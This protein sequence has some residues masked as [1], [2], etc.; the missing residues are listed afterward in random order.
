MSDEGQREAGAG[1][2]EERAGEGA[3]MS[4]LASAKEQLATLQE[5]LQEVTSELTSPEYL[6]FLTKRSEGASGEEKGTEES[7]EPDFDM[8]SQAELAR[9]LVK[10]QKQTDEELKRLIGEQAARV[11][12]ELTCLR[13]PKLRESLNDEKY[14]SQFRQ[15]ALDNPT[16]NAEKVYK[17]VE[18]ERRIAAEE[19]ARMAKEREEREFKARSEKA[20]APL[21]AVEGKLLSDEEA[22]E[23]AYRKVFGT[24]KDEE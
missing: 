6:E 22:E 18:I 14:V 4:E 21:S 17:Q 8:M 5:R 19:A 9:H 11:D 23:I 15:T 13:H 20:S 12:L 16:W 1:E 2:G 10:Q 3:Q 7:E 24:R